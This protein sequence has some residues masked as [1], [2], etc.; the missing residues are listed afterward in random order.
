MSLDVKIIINMKNAILFL[1][2]YRLKQ[3]YKNK[4]ERTL[5]IIRQLTLFTMYFHYVKIFKFR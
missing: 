1:N 2:L 5:N 3:M 4:N